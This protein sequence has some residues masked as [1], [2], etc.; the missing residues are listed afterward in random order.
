MIHVG[1]NE[2]TDLPETVALI[3]GA[4]RGRRF[5]GDIPKQYRLLDGEPVIRHTLRAFCSS[6]AVDHV[7][8]V[9]HPDDLDLFNEAADG[10]DIA[11]P[12]WG[13]DSRQDSVRLGLMHIA[14]RAPQRVLI[15]DAARPF[16]AGDLIE[17]VVA[18]LD[19]AVGAIPALPV[20]DTLK[21]ATDEADGSARIEATVSREGLWRAQTPQGFRFKEILAAHEKLRGNTLTDDAALA[22]HEGLPVRIVAGSEAN[23]KITTEEDLRRGQSVMNADMATYCTGSGFDV[24][25]FGD[26]EFVTLCGVRIEHSQGLVGHSD[27]DV[28]LHAVTDALLGAAGAGDIGDHFPPSD[29]QWRG[30]A[31]DLFLRHAASLVREMGGTICNVDV[32]LICEAPKIGPHREAMRTRLADILEIPPARSSVKATTTEGLGFTGRRQGIA[33]QAVATVCL[34]SDR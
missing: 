33:A 2:D 18:A 12:V 21:R 31:S 30:A 13:G 27:A 15:H 32:T 9:I 5:G 3:V 14:E 7:Q 20:T 22:E 26:G 25:T 6:N 4:G 8:A 1:L 28:A 16:V 24:H 17:R 10:L 11:S 29:P 23:V 34:P 19:H